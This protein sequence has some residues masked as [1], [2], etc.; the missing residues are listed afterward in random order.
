MQRRLHD[1]LPLES[2][3]S[4]NVLKSTSV[5][6]AALLSCVLLSAPPAFAQS[7]FPPAE[8][9]SAQSDSGTMKRADQDMARVLKKLMDLGAKPIGTM[10]VEETRNQP[11]PADAV[12]AVMKDDGKDPMT[13]MTAMKVDKK[14]M[15]YPVFGG[16]T[17][18][19]RIYTPEG[20][21]SSPRPVIVYYHG[22]GFVIAT[23]DTYEA[24]AMALAHKTGAIVVSAEYRHAPENK[25]PAAH[26]DAMAAYKWVLTNAPSFGGDATRI[27][28]A[29]ESAGGNLAANV[30]ITA[31]DE[32]IQEPA[33]M[34][35]VY[36]VAGTNLQTPSYKENANAMPLSLLALEW[37]Y[38]NSIKSEQDLQSPMLDLVGRA[39]LK[40]LPPA[41][42]INAEIDP[43]ESEGRQLATKLREAG[44]KVTHEVYKGVTHE[45]FGMAPLIADAEKAQ[46][47]A[48]RELKAAFQ[49]TR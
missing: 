37:F 46:D 28:V 47:L 23:I 38:K 12:K 5:S 29:G 16:E 48:A 40:G 11:Q 7:A 45:F 1:R 22:G 15:T 19:I 9:P 2:E 18:P 26:E 24:S 49:H 34:L 30:A 31:R 41:T 21:S 35:L 14:D 6:A 39:N 4:M 3:L 8:V 17:Q 10:S 32:L 13:V 42:I 44:V 20:R 27:A 33:H 43:L 36:P 25:A